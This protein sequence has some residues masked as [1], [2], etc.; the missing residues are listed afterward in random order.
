[1]IGSVLL[2][3]RYVLIEDSRHVN[4]PAGARARGALPFA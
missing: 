2:G 1:M 4:A 3:I